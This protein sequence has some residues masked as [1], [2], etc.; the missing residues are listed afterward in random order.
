MAH[1]LINGSAVAIHWS[2]VRGLTIQTWPRIVSISSSGAFNTT[3]IEIPE[4]PTPSRNLVPGSR[5]S[6]I[7]KI[8]DFRN[9]DPRIWDSGS[10]ALPV[11]SWRPNLVLPFPTKRGMGPHTWCSAYGWTLILSYLT[12]NGHES[13]E[14]AIQSPFDYLSLASPG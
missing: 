14:I 7:P 3:S 4:E 10:G 2:H 9:S 13:Y 8:P 12:D 1:S 11:G 6:E 5:F